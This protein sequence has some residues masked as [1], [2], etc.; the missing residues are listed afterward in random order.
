MDGGYALRSAGARAPADWRTGA[1]GRLLGVRIVRLYDASRQ[2][3]DWM[4]II[5]PGQFAVFASLLDGGEPCDIDGVPTGHGAASCVIVDALAEAEALCR[6]RA[7]RHPSVRLDV[8]DIAGRSQPPLLTVVHPSRIRSLEGDAAVRRR[9][10]AIAVTL[11]VAAPILCW[12][13]WQAGGV[14]VLPTLFAI[15]GLFFALRL[16][17]LNASYAAAER[18]RLERMTGRQDAE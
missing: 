13:D 18:R 6:E 7:E 4:D 3:R 5:R 1:C 17:Q 11:V 10:T 16:L 14:L 12:I 8:F 15:N 9:N 2:P